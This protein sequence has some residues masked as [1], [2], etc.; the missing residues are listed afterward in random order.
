[1]AETRHPTKEEWQSTLDFFNTNL[2]E[3]YDWNIQQEY[4]LAMN[5]GNLN[6]FRIV[7]DQDKIVEVGN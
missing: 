3:G 7:K 5:Q 2:R 6:N 1:M 4:P